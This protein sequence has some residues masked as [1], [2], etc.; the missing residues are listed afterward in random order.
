MTKSG[1][2]INNDYNE[3]NMFQY[4]ILSEGAYGK[5]GKEVEGYSIDPELS[6]QHRTTYVKDGKA[7]VAFRGTDL[8]GKNKW[9]DLGTDMLITLGLQN[10]SSRFRN[11]KKTTQKAIQKYGKENVNVTGH[12]L[13]GSTALYVNSKLGTEAHAFNPGV[14]PVDVQKSGGIFNINHVLGFFGKKPKVRA[15]AHSYIT[16][17]DPISML[18]PFLPNLNTHI[19]KKKHKNPHALKNFLRKSGQGIKRMTSWI[20]H[21][22]EHASKNGISYKQA[23]KDARA[24]YKKGGEIEVEEIKEIEPEPEPVKKRGRGSGVT[25]SMDMPLFIRLL[26]YAREDAKT[27]VDLHNVAENAQSFSR[28]L[29]MRDYKKLVGGKVGGR[30]TTDASY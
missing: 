10:L 26:E 19:I 30:V 15:N 17:Y 25:L 6:N 20:Q 22:K 29:K 24:S 18:S 9:A 23:L 28:T 7:I 14:S 8:S 16:G 5:H 2:G 3:D 21:V 12:S 27:D 13:G 1:I 4:A 11:A